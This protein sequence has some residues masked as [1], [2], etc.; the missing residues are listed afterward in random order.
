MML[1]TKVPL[2][3][4]AL[5]FGF[6]DQ[7]YFTRVFSPGVGCSP[8]SWRRPL[9]NRRVSYVGLIISVHRPG[10]SISAAAS[11][12]DRSRPIIGLLP[13]SRWI[14]RR[15]WIHDVG[16]ALAASIHRIDRS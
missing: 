3:D 9:D 13:G 2:A 8:G 15:T 1:T 10:R 6:G 11:L 16:F 7:G 4:I 14:S 12:H 5:I